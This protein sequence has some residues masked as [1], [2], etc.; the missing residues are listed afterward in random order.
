MSLV[1]PEIGLLFWMVVIFGIVFFLLAKFGFPVITRMV[2]E[3]SAK[4]ARS[5]KDADEIQAR[6]EAWKVEQAKMLEQTRREQSAM[7][8]E[9]AQTKARIVEDARTEARAQADKIISEAKVQIAAEKESALREVRREV[10]VLSV[11][12]AEKILRHQLEDSGNQRMFID[13]LVDEADKTSL[14]G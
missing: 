3:R 8:K 5:L 9:A 7:L 6:M 2:D 14:K 13:S 4:I 11:Q 1:T 10:A 12:V